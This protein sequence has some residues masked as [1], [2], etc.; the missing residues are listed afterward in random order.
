MVSGGWEPR[1]PAGCTNWRF[2]QYSADGNRQ[3]SNHGVLSWDVDLDVFNGTVAELR[4]WAGVG[5]A[6]E[7]PEPAGTWN[8]FI[9]DLKPRLDELK[10]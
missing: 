5:D 3:G 4:A 9:E 7:E 8:Q 6:L 2:W 1:L 10:V